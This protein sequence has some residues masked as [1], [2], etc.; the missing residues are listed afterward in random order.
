MNWE[1]LIIAGLFETAGT[2]GMKYSNG[3]SKLY[4]S[5]IMVLTINK[6]IPSLCI[7]KNFVGCLGICCMDWNRRC[8]NYSFGS[9][10]FGRIKRTDKGLFYFSDYYRNYR[11]ENYFR[12]IKYLLF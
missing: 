11:T 1:I 7:I 2:I 6:C 10:P 4:P 3:F 9:N 5:L 12:E 8:R